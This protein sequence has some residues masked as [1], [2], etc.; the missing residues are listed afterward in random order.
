[1]SIAERDQKIIEIRLLENQINQLEQQITLIDRQ[2]LELQIMQTNLD[3]IKKIKNDNALVPIGKDIFV[4]SDIKSADKVLVNVG[5]GIF[6]KKTT[7]G[8]KDILEKQNKKL[9]DI[10]K[11]VINEVNNIFM[12]ITN[13]E[14]ELA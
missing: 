11:E 9:L 10:R 14:K 7:E 2:I 3:D 6:V 8:A 5:Y 4:E 1:M 12:K 13:I